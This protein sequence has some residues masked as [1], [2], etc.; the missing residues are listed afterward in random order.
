MKIRTLLLA[1]PF[2]LFFQCSMA[3]PASP[4]QMLESTANNIIKALQKNKSQLKKQPQIINGIVKQYLL[5]KVDVYGM[6]RTVLGRNAWRQASSQQRKVFTRE[7]TKL[8]I[9]TYSGALSDFDNEKVKFLPLRGNYKN[10]RY[11]RINSIILRGNGRRIPLSY[12]LVRKSSSWKVYDMS[13]E[14]VSLL[15]SFRSQFSQELAQGSM[16]QLINKLKK[17]NQKRVS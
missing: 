11:V 14:G 3:Q 5:P 10:K 2:V 7:F 1:I 13:V 17:H 4:T 9:R 16:Q 12:S 15:Q 6:S 8:V